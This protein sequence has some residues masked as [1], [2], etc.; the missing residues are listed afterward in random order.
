[1]KYLLKVMKGIPELTSHGLES[2]KSK[3]YS[4]NRNDLATYLNFNKFEL[5]CN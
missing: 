1:M 5:C 2:Q 4:K 3:D